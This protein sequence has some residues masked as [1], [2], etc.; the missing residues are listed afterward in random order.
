MKIEKYLERFSSL[1]GKNVIVTGANAGIGFELS[2]HLLSLKANLFMACRNKQ[3]AEN[4][5]EKLLSNYPQSHIEILLYD[6]ANFN[7]IKDFVK[8]IR[9]LNIKIDYLVCN[10]GVYFPKKKMQTADGLELTVGTNYFG[11]VY[12]LD[13]LEEKLIKNQTRVVVVSSLTGTLSK[14][15]P[16][17]KINSLSR[18]KLYGFSKY[19]ISTSTYERMLENKYPV[20]LVH[21]GICSTNI[22]NN[23]DT[24][25]SSTFA[26]LGRKFLNVFVHSAKKASLCLLEGMVS[27]YHEFMYIAP[28]GIFSISGYPKIKKVPNKFRKEKVLDKT[29]VYLKSGGNYVIS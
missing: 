19:L 12:L 23:K 26:L 3:R 1:E 25:L 10:A 27:D 6:Q 2:K 20:V 18:N 11:Q 28:N 14:N 29:R 4:A 24:G 17:E 8:K 21:P 22:L 15:R 13:L 7:S 16:L 5:K 9:E